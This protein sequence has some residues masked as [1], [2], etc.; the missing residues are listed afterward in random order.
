MRGGAPI[1]PCHRLL[2]ESMPEIH[3]IRV[4]SKFDSYEVIGK[5]SK[6][7]DSKHKG[8]YWFCRCECGTEKTV[9]QVTLTKPGEHNCGCKSIQSRGLRDVYCIWRGIIYRCT[10]AENDSYKDYGGRG[11]KVC[12]RW[13]DEAEGFENFIKD[14]GPRPSM[15]YSVDRKNV[16]GDYEPLNCRWATQAEQMRNMRTNVNL[17]HNGITMCK[18]DWAVSLG[19]HKNTFDKRL[20]LGWSMERIVATPAQQ[21]YATKKR[22]TA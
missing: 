10:D 9:A 20:A 17:T 3:L 11:I 12:E 22:H 4:G 7:A 15:D 1:V 19:L 13:L 5:G 8:R 6:P 21:Q 18:V 2:G 14:M 16:N